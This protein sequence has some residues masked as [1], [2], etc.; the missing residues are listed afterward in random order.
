MST[1]RDRQRNIRRK[2]G[3]GEDDWVATPGEEIVI[4]RFPAPEEKGK[5][6]RC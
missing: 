3:K 5:K 4:E 6:C 1:Q 2:T